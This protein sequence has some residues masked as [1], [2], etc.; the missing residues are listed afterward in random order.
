[1]TVGKPLVQVAVQEKIAEERKKEKIKHTKKAK[2]EVQP[3][4]IS[5]KAETAKWK[6]EDI[7]KVIK[8]DLSTIQY[9]RF[10]D[11][12]YVGW[13]MFEAQAIPQLMEQ[14]RE[15]F[16]KTNFKFP[17]V[18][19]TSMKVMCTF[20]ETQ[21]PPIFKGYRTD[22]IVKIQYIANNFEQVESVM[23]MQLEEVIEKTAIFPN[24]SDIGVED[25]VSYHVRFWEYMPSVIRKANSIYAK[26]NGFIET[27]E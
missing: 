26:G 19:Q 6:M 12:R 23:R 14:F 15:M 9:K 7:I 17:I 25:V 3:K 4:E 21:R 1:M 16:P 8:L 20:N 10:P 27:P 13:D 18:L 11:D 2:V 22:S 5:E 24:G